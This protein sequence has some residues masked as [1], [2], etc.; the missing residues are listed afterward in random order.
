MSAHSLMKTK[1]K[2]LASAGLLA[3]LPVASMP[4]HGQTAPDSTE[5]DKKADENVVKL[6]TF[7]VKGLRGSL[8][9]AAEIKQSKHEIVDSIVASDI[10]KLPD[11][12]A[13][14]A[15]SR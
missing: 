13:S 9:S 4:L 10:D 11:M 8:S 3:L 1:L 15:L 5:S 2:T 14:Y 6:D 7:E 12:N